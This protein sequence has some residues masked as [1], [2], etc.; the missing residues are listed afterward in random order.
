MFP[1]LNLPDLDALDPAA[2]KANASEVWLEIG[3]GG[4]EHMA[5][6]AS[7]RPE[8]LVLG[9]EGP[10]LPDREHARCDRTVR[11]PMAE[12]VDSLNVAAAGAILMHWMTA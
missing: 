10:G 12:G 3:F 6:Q 8:A 7:G 11:I 2:L 5:A 9:A 4:G 1:A